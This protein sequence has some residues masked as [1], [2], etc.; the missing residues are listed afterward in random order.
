MTNTSVWKVIV[1]KVFLTQSGRKN[2]IH[3]TYKMKDVKVEFIY[4]F[5]TLLIELGKLFEYFLMMPETFN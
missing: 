4:V 1:L 3:Q 5:H 2:W